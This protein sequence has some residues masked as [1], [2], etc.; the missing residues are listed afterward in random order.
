MWYALK[1][2]GEIRRVRCFDFEPTIFDFHTAI[3]HGFSYEI[4]PVEVREI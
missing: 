4:V 3:L 2:N 1:V